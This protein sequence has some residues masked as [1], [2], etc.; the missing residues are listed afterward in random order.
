MLFKL[1]RIGRMIWS[2]HSCQCANIKLLSNLSAY[3]GPYCFRPYII[4]LAILVYRSVI[5]GRYCIIR[6]LQSNVLSICLALDRL[7][8]FSNI[9]CQFS[10]IK[11]RG[12]R[13]CLFPRDDDIIANIEIESRTGEN[14]D[15]HW[16]G[17]ASLSLKKYRPLAKAAIR[18]PL[19]YA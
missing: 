15:W 8:K 12:F 1:I 9:F 3:S 19:Q 17:G 11:L 10:K 5:F 2:V 7:N 16:V 13:F 14:V 4:S 6:L 18:L